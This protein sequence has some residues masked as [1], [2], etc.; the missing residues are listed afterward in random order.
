MSRSLMTLI[1]QLVEDSLLIQLIQAIDDD[2]LLRLIEHVG[3]EDAGDII[4]LA[5]FTQLT[6]IFD[7]VFWKNARPGEREKFD[8]QQFALWLEV[9]MEHSAGTAKKIVADM[10]EDLL[11]LGLAENLLVVDHESF[12]L[13]MQNPARSFEDDL[14]DKLLDSE[15]LMEWG[16]M[17][18]IP[19]NGCNNWDTLIALLVDLDSEDSDRI[20]RILKTINHISTEYIE[21]NG[22]LYNVLTSGEMLENDL[23]AERETRREQQGYVSPEAATAFLQQARVTSVEELLSATGYDYLTTHY[24]TAFSPDE[25]LQ[26][27]SKISRERLIKYISDS[28]PVIYKQFTDAGIIVLEES[29]KFPAISD[30]PPSQTDIASALQFIEKDDTDIFNKC[31]YELHYLANILLAG[32][33]SDETQ[34][35][36]IEAAEKTMKIC[37]SGMHY[38]LGPAQVSNPECVRQQILQDGLVKIFRIGWHVT[39]K[40][41]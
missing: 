37:Q 36:P 22:G 34:L 35:T 6:H 25:S 24:F 17:F 15:Q 5:S 39:M 38:V 23:A 3:V 20:E 8:P 27:A 2:Q 33:N 40:H 30:S 1:Y 9:A 7:N 31:L 29:K 18:I 41:A 28:F 4:S 21:D 16:E 13:R 10:D 19:K 32:D 26:K 11:V 14:L 12:L